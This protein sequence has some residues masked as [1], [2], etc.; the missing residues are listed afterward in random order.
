MIREAIQN[1]LER[2]SRDCSTGN[3]AMMKINGWIIGRTSHLDDPRP[4]S[5]KERDDGFYCKEFANII[6]MFLKKRPMNIADGKYHLVYKDENGYQNCVVAVNNSFKTM[7]FIT[8]M[9]LNKR[10]P[11]DYKTRGGDKRI[12]IG[13]KD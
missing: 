1:I 8:I 2:V 7:T 6:K 13:N 4:P 12:F 3:G 10:N 11:N 9:Q 5:E